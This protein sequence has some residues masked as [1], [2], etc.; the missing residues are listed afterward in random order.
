MNAG[1]P[2][3]RAHAANLLLDVLAAA[4]PAG[5]VCLIGSLA[6]PDEA[7]VFSDIDLRW[8]LPPGQAAGPLESL[9]ST[10]RQVGVVES[11]RVDPDDRPDFLLVF[12]RFEGWPLWWLVDL[13][14]HSAGLAS[15][16][17]PDPD[18]WSS[19]ESACMGVV[20][21]LKTLARNRPEEA[22]TFFVRALQRV[23][24]RDVAGDWPL[25][26][27]SLLD[28]IETRSPPTA[29]LVSRTRHL[30]PTLGLSLSNDPAAVRGE[31][32][33]AGPPGPPLTK[34]KS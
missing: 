30:L 21:T 2:A 28:D 18:P 32:G 9:R 23:E 20:V 11:L 6:A 17:L 8:T 1:P 5:E 15:T 19:E 31:D 26:I 33:G 24:A 29:D 12:I 4:C 14:I 25:R 22:E 13:E 7:D 34:E 27:G 10:L 16:D 3:S